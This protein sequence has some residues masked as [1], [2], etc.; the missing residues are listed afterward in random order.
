MGRGLRCGGQIKDENKNK[1]VSGY[2]GNLGF[3]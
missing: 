3:V 2:I 1:G